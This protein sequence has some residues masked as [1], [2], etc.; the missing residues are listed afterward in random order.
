MAHKTKNFR[1]STVQPRLAVAKP[2]KA[3][4]VM[5][6]KSRRMGESKRSATRLR[7]WLERGQ[8]CAACGR[9]VEHPVGY[10]LDHIVPLVLGG[11]DDDSNLQ[12]LCVWID[13]EGR[14]Q[15]CHAQKSAE[16]GSH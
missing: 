13:E 7:L 3:L 2:P 1:L 4:T 9:M 14:K 6:T 15:G 11:T 16:D 8:C 12:L 10:E 5:T